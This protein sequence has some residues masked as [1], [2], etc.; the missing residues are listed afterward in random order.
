M[1]TAHLIGTKV[2]PKNVGRVFAGAKEHLILLNYGIYQDYWG[3]EKDLECFEVF[4]SWFA[5]L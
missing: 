3:K 1:F 2:L 5:L 4:L